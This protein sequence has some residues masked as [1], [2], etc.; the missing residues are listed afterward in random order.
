VPNDVSNARDGAFEAWRRAT[1]A[2][3]YQ[4]A[5]LSL[6]FGGGIQVPGAHI[7]DE[8]TYV[9]EASAEPSPEAL[10]AARETVIEGDWDEF[11]EVGHGE[12]PAAAAPTAS[13]APQ[14]AATPD[15][16]DA[17]I[18]AHCIAN[19]GTTVTAAK[20]KAAKVLGTSSLLHWSGPLDALKAALEG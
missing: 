1:R 18:K 12:T 2:L 15:E 13:N 14:T 19:P 5:D 17:T 7:V 11:G 9:F 20:A 8:D 3:C 16:I 10:E 4:I 6:K